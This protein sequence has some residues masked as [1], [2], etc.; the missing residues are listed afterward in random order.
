MSAFS[1]RPSFSKWE[2]D[3][4]K[5]RIALIDQLLADNGAMMI[6]DLFRLVRTTD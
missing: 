6:N 2:I 1:G 4:E 3:L 5:R